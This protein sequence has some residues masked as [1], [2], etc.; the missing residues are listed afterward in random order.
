MQEE[1]TSGLYDLWAK[2]YDYTFGALVRNRQRRAIEQFHF[3]PGDKVLDLGVGT[4]MM[5]K[6]YPQDIQVVGMDLSDGMLRKA[7]KKRTD[8]N[9]EGCQLVRADAMFPPF[10]EHTFDHIMISHTVSVVSDPAK[11]MKWAS[12]MV[13]P[14]GRIVV[15]NHFQSTNPLIGWVERTI[16][17]VMVKIGWKSDLALEDTLIGVDLYVD[18]AFQM[19]MFD[20]WKIVVFTTRRPPAYDTAELPAGAVQEPAI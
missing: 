15:L 8:L 13:K 12:R 17:P 20:I 2:F 7:E 4:G 19:R 6:H 14:G 5:L 11:L 1:S 3:S 18:Y 10:A 16:N 9:F